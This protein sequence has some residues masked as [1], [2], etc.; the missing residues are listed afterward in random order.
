MEL[1]FVLLFELLSQLVAE[2][3][4]ATLLPPEPV[5]PQFGKVAFVGHGGAVSFQ[6][7]VM[8]SALVLHDK[9]AVGEDNQSLAS[10]CQLCFEVSGLVLP[11]DEVRF[12]QGFKC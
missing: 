9:E 2:E 8:G 12:C 3:L 5:S 6:E 11:K 4:V 10:D 1:L 7:K